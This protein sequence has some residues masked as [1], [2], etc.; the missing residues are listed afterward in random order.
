MT[1]NYTDRFRK[2]LEICYEEAINKNIKYI[3]PEFLLWGIFREGM[4]VGSKYLIEN[5]GIDRTAIMQILESILSL[6]ENSMDIGDTP[7][8]D[9]DAMM[10]I[11]NAAKVCLLKRDTAITPLHIVY[12]ILLSNK[13]NLLKDLFNNNNVDMADIEELKN[14]LN[15]ISAIVDVPKLS[16]KPENQ[17]M[18]EENDVEDEDA[19]F[20]FP[21]NDD[22]EEQGAKSK[23]EKQGKA[24]SK[25]PSLDLFARDITADAEKGEL[26]P[27]IGRDK[28]IERI[29]QILGR[30]KKSNP[31]LVG[32]PGVG[33]TSIIEGLAQ[34][35][36][37]DDV[38][39]KLLGKRIFSLDVGS[40]VAGSK[41]R[42]QFEE[43]LKA[44][45][46]ELEREKNI[47][48]F[49]DEIH[50]IIGSGNVSGS[51]DMANML[52]PA[53]SSG[54][55]QCI[56]TTTME[57]YRKTIEQ[58]SALDRR[59]QR[60]IVDQNSKEETEEILFN[61]KK[62]YEDYHLVKYTDEAIRA[63][64]DLSERYINDRFFPD[65]AID[66]LDE[67]GA[68]FSSVKE[69]KP[70]S[71]NSIK[72]ELKEVAKKK[73]EAISNQDFDKASELSEK[74]KELK[75][76]LKEEEADWQT[77]KNN[78]RAIIDV[79]I[80]E[81]I[82]SKIS[83]IPVEKINTAENSNLKNM[84]TKI[85]EYIVGQDTAIDKVSK[86]V[87]RSKLGLRDGN[88][89]MGTFLFLGPTGV[90]KTELAKRLSEYLFGSRDSMIRIDMS[91]YMEKFAV[92]RLVGAPPGYVG[93]DEGG[94]LTEQVR[95]NPY[96]VILFDEI[97]KAHPDVY[98]LLLQIMDE[99]FITDSEGR[100]INFTHSIIIL[101]SNVGSRDL[102]N[103]GKG[104]GYNYEQSE[105]SKHFIIKKALEKQFSPEFLNRIDE[106]IEFNALDKSSIRQI[107]DIELE[108]IY[109]IYD[110][111]GY[112]LSVS[113]EAKDIIV[114]KN[115][116]EN[117]GARP[118]KR[119]LQ[120]ELDDRIV[121]YILEN[122]TEKGKQIDLIANNKELDIVIND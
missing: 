118:I 44:V 69:N 62:K 74:E 31:I 53:L 104:L 109:K 37:K 41:Y 116:D 122:G 47:I 67:A 10:V 120:R 46:K 108:R 63:I 4:N 42:G 72:D 52:K 83:K 90:G 73:K 35:I 100:K 5:K 106:I 115:Y 6:S 64:V 14:S 117:F 27:V 21:N 87:Q 56:G 107:I 76:S 24:K 50:T 77:S 36:I 8:F 45:I 85:R 86:A 20:S 28:E 43:R 78:D 88:K 11:A 61:I 65:K 97:E 3:S 103:F 68:F 51:L 17:D 55:I 66:V 113:D 89:P 84:R 30:R 70:N 96:S 16:F 75:S 23:N 91:E 112:K 49:I 121:A 95:R 94:Q 34:K 26:D 80:I 15:N 99:G 54:R 79:D 82:I 93:Y 19:E 102:K 110:K 39:N 12:G 57:E 25:T 2:V 33:K 98:N 7:I 105:E 22:I 60:L 111:A 9:E 29:T 40:M 58:D 59:F 18:N 1:Y 13:S 92:S 101:T 38:G 71:I 114:D 32:D 48:L 81:K 119:A